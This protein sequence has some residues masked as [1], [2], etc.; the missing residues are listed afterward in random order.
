MNEVNNETAEI[1]EAIRDLTRVILV[2][3][4][5]SANKS[6]IIR[7]LHAVSISPARIASLL[8]METKDVTSALSKAKKR[9]EDDNKDD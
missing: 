2:L 5:Q 3:D 4:N 7:R 1:V 9:I 8:G 6:D